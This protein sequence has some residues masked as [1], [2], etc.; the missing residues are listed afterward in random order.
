MGRELRRK[1]AEEANFLIF[2]WQVSNSPQIY[3]HRATRARTYVSCEGTQCGSILEK[4]K[5]IFFL[6]N[7]FEIPAN[8]FKLLLLFLT[9]P[10]WNLPSRRHV[11]KV[12]R[13]AS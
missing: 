6:V 3:I 12:E 10:T 2:L 7:S 11:S 4:E 9:E 5:K 1:K 13:T 8:R